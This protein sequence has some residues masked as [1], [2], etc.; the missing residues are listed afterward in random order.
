MSRLPKHS[1]ALFGCLLIFA[2]LAVGV[3]G[4]G[5]SGS[6]GGAP[7]I[8]V[9]GANGSKDYTFDQLK[10]MKS[11][12]GYAGIKNSA[13]NITPPATMKGVLIEDLFKDVGGLSDDAA[14]G[15][16]AK[17]GYEMT[18]SAAQMKTGDFLTYD[19][20][21]GAEIKVDEPLKVI[22]A[23]EIDGK[24][25]DPTTEGPLRLAIITAQKNQVT[26]GH[27]SV[28]WV[29]KLQVKA[30]EKEWSLVLK[31]AIA[32]E[33]DKA[34]FESGAASGCHG[35]DWTDAD[36][37]R[38]T[39]IPL[40]F[41]VGRVDDDVSHDGPAYNRDLAQAGYQVKITSDDGKTV[42]IDSKTMY[43]NRKLLV[44][45]KLNGQPLTGD[46][47]PLRLVGDGLSAENMIG[48]VSQIEALVPA[49]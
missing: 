34:T 1:L 41:L 46:Y 6:T 19:T 17:D 13:G 29:T 27:W 9:V 22:I 30:V 2:V 40:Y 25:I 43:Y 7:A 11:V 14:V 31:G 39:G 47:W 45:Y 44:A 32:E 16:M 36:G 42:E 28:K 26:D 5:D 8:T 12:E 24:P 49:K 21:T 23:Y 48:K 15:I 18:M 35:N 37:N 38:W 3:A 20:V 10:K 33:V 4:C